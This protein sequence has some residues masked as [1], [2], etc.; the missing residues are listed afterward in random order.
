M[1]P[2][3]PRSPGPAIVPSRPGRS[4]PDWQLAIPTRPTLSRQVR[5]TEPIRRGW[6][7]PA[8]PLAHGR[9]GRDR[10]PV[11]SIVAPRACDA[12]VV[13][14]DGSTAHVR[15]VRAGD[16][17]AVRSLYASLS[18]RSRYLRFF[19]V[20][21]S[22]N[23]VV[24]WATA[25]SDHRRFGL[26]VTAGGDGQ[27]VAH[28]ARRP[29]RR[30][31]P[32]PPRTATTAR[33]ATGSEPGGVLGD[34]RASA[35]QSHRHHPEQRKAAPS[36]QLLPEPGGEQHGANSGERPSQ[37]SDQFHHDRHARRRRGGGRDPDALSPQDR[38]RLLVGDQPVRRPPLQPRRERLAHCRLT[39][40]RRRPD[41]VRTIEKPL[42]SMT[43][44]ERMGPDGLYR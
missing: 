16:E 20:A 31:T 34:H 33:R 1:D 12:D 27:V 7:R 25:T 26:V 5:S 3:A 42:P 37:V 30:R 40:W 32:P 17:D 13:L 2:R 6:H 14:R 35:P 41:L 4:T 8:T 15:P 23:T 11:V 21:P 29:C 44:A 38:R 10:E 43:T 24:A 22:L 36:R 18:E 39:G 9:I 19:S 28:G